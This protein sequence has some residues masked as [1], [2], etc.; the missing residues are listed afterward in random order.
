M[1]ANIAA[2]ASS[3]SRAAVRLSMRQRLR[4]LAPGKAEMAT[5]RR[6]DEWLDRHQ[7]RFAS[8]H[9]EEAWPRSHAALVRVTVAVALLL[10]LVAALL[11]VTGGP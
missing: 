6:Q 8:G 2:A 4:A 11:A 3:R 9:D 10:L 1:R 5:S 7:R